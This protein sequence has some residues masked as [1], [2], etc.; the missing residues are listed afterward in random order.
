MW[1]GLFCSLRQSRPGYT[2]ARV[3]PYMHILC[4]HVRFFIKQYGCFKKFTGQGVEKNINDSKRA[5]Y[6]KSNKWDSAID[7]LFLEGGQWKL[8]QHGR[9]KSTYTKRNSDYWN[10][11][12]TNQRKKRKVLYTT[13]LTLKMKLLGILQHHRLVDFQVDY[14]RFTVR[15]LREEIKSKGLGQKGL[16]NMKK[17]AL[18]SS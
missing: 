9:K 15:Q 1:I 7:I 14:K 8:K 5:L 11:E 10:V 2:K 16:A 17:A 12:I 6:Q 13:P 4:Y 3:T 18:V